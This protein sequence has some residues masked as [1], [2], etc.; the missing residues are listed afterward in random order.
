MQNDADIQ[1]NHNFICRD[2]YLSALISALGIPLIKIA[3]ENFGKVVFVFA[4]KGKCEEI[5]NDYINNKI[6]INANILIAKIKALKSQIYIIKNTYTE[7]NY[8]KIG[9]NFTENIQ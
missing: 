3:K 6:K 8:E 4:D 5:I 9:K 1:N 2:F 7:N